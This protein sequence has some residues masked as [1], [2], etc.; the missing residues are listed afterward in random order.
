M[1]IDKSFV[2]GMAA[3]RNFKTIVKSVVAMA[4]DLDLSVVAEGVENEEIVDTLR[5]YGC[6]VAQ[7]YFYGKP[8]AGQAF[9]AWLKANGEPTLH[10]SR[11]G[12]KQA[13]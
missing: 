4:H 13:G 12:A 9:E 5:E 2:M 6:D 1:K 7:G 10:R 11:D 3:D 8:M